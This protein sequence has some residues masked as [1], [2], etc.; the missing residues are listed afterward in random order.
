M[1]PLLPELLAAGLIEKLDGDDQRYAK[2]EKAAETLA[3]GFREKPVS[4]IRAMLASL[5]PDISAHDPII[6]Q[7]KQA[8]LGEWKT[9]SSVYADEPIGL[10]RTLLLEAC[11]QCSEGTQ[12]AILWLTAADTL[13]LFRLGGEEPVIAHALKAMAVRAEEAASVEIGV[14]QPALSAL[15]EPEDS[16]AALAERAVDQ[17]NLLLRVAATAGPTYRTNGKPLS[18]PNPQWTNGP[19]AWSWD[20]ADRM[21]SL[22]AE[23]LNA[24]AVDMACEQHQLLSRVTVLLNTQQQ[25]VSTT[26]GAHETR[27]RAERLRLD[28]L[29]WSEALY[30]PSLCCSYRELPEGLASVLMAVDLLDLVNLPAPAG[31][32]HMLAETVHRLPG[33]GYEKKQPFSELLSALR[34]QRAQLPE[35][36]AGKFA[37]PPTEGRLSLRDLLVLALGD[38][39]WNAQA[40]LARAG[41][42]GELAM[43]LPDLAHALFRQEQAVRLAE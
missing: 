17:D 5:D 35:D 23:E 13:P 9:M 6:Q 7:A 1:S 34:E 14:L 38:K 19:Q 16:S 31:V 25:W 28:A 32:G 20:F 39:E 26:L 3:Q 33:A 2:L 10:Y 27:R 18:D 29:W 21:T 22:L 40:A 8:L 4:L 11:H 41:I 37:P 43:S 12:A 42:V 15:H 24:L 36:L 30:S